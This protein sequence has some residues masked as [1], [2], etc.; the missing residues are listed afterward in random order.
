MLEQGRLVSPQVSGVL[1]E[2]F[3]A[4]ELEF[5]DDNFVAGL[6]GR[7]VRM[8][9]KNGL[10]EDW[11]LDA[12]RVERGDD[13]Y[14]IVGMARHRRGN[15]YLRQLAAEVDEQIFGGVERTRFRHRLVQL[16]TVAQPVADRTDRVLRTAPVTI[17]APIPFN[18]ALVSW[19]IDVPDGC[20]FTVEIRVG[21]RAVEGWSPFLEVGQWGQVPADRPR[22]IGFSGGKI[23]VDYFRYDYDGPKAAK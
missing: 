2:I 18:E 13:L 21:R 11:H 10:W 1:R 19:N 4:P 16:D 6:R 8:I 9:R 14:L 5:H 7:N 3:E 15:E 22:E 12:A 23:D 17:D 20:G